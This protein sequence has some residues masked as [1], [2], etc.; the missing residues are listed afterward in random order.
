MSKRAAILAGLA[1]AGMVIPGMA[2]A[3]AAS[4]QAPQQ[5]DVAPWVAMQVHPKVHLL[6][7]PDDYFGP[8]VGNVILI[9]QNDGFV[10]IDSGLNAGNGRKLVAYARF[11][12]PKPIKAVAITHWHNDHPQGVSSIRD[13]YPNVRIIS[14]EA[15][16][17]GM[18]GPGLGFV[19]R[20]REHRLEMPRHGLPVL[21]E[22][23]VKLPPT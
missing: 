12:S 22:G 7:T 23:F 18:L 16:E 9:E 20:F 13:A 15:T 17:A 19:L 2:A 3:P 14:T 11:L 21:L 1:M 6:A 10:V 5:P 8:A 4:A